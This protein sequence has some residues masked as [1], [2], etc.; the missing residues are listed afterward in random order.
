MRGLGKAT[1][2]DGDGEKRREGVSTSRVV[3][4]FVAGVFVG[5]MAVNV[6][7]R[8][9]LGVPLDW[10]A[11]E[12]PRT[13]ERTPDPVAVLAPEAHPPVELG[14]SSRATGRSLYRDRDGGCW[15]VECDSAG[16]A[17]VC[18]GMPGG[19]GAGGSGGGDWHE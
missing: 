5:G 3:A 9:T 7:L 6:V 14:A 4:A 8:A 13:G 18:V 12:E 11:A 17:H 1:G 2:A 15:D 10:H 19:S 16:H